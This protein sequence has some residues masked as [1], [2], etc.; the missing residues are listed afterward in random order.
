VVRRIVVL[1][2]ALVM[3]TSATAFAQYVP[4]QPGF[5]I[6]PPTVPSTGGQVT[7]TGVGC[8]PG[9]EVQAFIIVDG[10]EVF[11]G[12][13]FVDD[14][15]DGPFEFLADIPALPPGEYTIIVKCGTLT[16]SNILTVTGTTPTSRQV[17]PLPR[18]GSDTMGFVR[19]GLGLVAVGGL[20]LLANKRRRGEET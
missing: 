3:A 10:Q 12:G 16:M 7:I 4:G 15:P 18:T 1:A 19:I 2:L 11:I 8:P 6:D 20:L 5:E 13:G 14:D 9:S 17:T